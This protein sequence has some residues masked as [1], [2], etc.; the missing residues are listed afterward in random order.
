MRRV[1]I[2]LLAIALAIIPMTAI[3]VE[4]NEDNFAVVANTVNFEM[5]YFGNYTTPSV[6]DVGT[7]TDHDFTINQK[8]YD[9]IKTHAAN[10][11][12]MEKAYTEEMTNSI[13]LV[14]KKNLSEMKAE[15]EKAKAN[16]TRMEAKVSLFMK[17]KASTIIGTTANEM[18]NGHWITDYTSTG[19][20]MTRTDAPFVTV[21]G[22]NSA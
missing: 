3:A 22:I 14:K 13:N 6:E 5:T 15:E 4:V 18:T 12:L 21:I 8:K 16:I 1:S 9:V 10:E 20:L 7:T 19:N 11:F 2:L 17:A